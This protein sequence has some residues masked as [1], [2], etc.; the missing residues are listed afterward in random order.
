MGKGLGDLVIK[1]LKEKTETRKIIKCDDFFELIQ[2]MG[3]KDDS[4]EIIDIVNYLEDNNTDINFHN[5]KTKDYYSRYKNI[6][7]KVQLSKMLRGTKTEVQLMIEKVDKIKV[8][9]RPDWLE[10]Y[11]DDE[12]SPDAK[13]SDNKNQYQR[14]TDMLT[15]ELKDK[16]ENEPGPTLEELQNEVEVE[17]GLPIPFNMN[18]L[19]ANELVDFLTNRV[20]PERFRENNNN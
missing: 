1:I 7:K 8:S 5:A 14:I 13:V 3:L 16:I 15:Q 9:E 20:I 18:E 6:E 19:N 4:E 17:M 2:D 12:E 11:R 10:F